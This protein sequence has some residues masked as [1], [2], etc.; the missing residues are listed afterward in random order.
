MQ[1]PIMILMITFI[2]I[3]IIF[4]FYL[5]LSSRQDKKLKTIDDSGK[6]KAEEYEKKEHSEI[7]KSK[8]NETSGSNATSLK[9]KYVKEDVYKL[10]EFDRILDDMIV[11]KNGSRF[12]MAIQCKG[13]NYDLMSEVE[14]LSVEEGFITFLNTLKYPIQLYVQAQNIDLKTAIDKFKS[15]VSPLKEEYDEVNEKYVKIVSAFDANENEVENITKKKDSISNVYEYAADIISYVEKM[16]LN[17]NLLQRKFYILVSYNTSD[18]AAVDKFSKDE[19]VSM[20]STELMTR[21]RAIISALASCSVTGKMLNSNEL[22]DLLYSA[23]N[24]DDKG[25]LSV[26]EAIESGFFRLYSTSEDAFTKRQNALDE[27]IKNEAKIRALKAMKDVIENGTIETPASEMIEQEEEISRRATNLVKNSNYDPSFES[28]VNKKILN[29][30]RETKKELQEIDKEQKEAI[31]EEYERDVEEMKNIKIEKPEGIE[32]I[33]KSKK[34]EDEE[35]YGITN[36]L[37]NKNENIQEI[38]QEQS[39]DEK[40]ENIISA[41]DEESFKPAYQ[42]IKDNEPVNKQSESYTSNENQKI[43]NNSESSDSDLYSSEE[44]ETII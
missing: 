43:D 39:R 41:S 5:I 25:I 11:Q 30:F 6:V 12:T 35:K 40:Q 38:I 22:A 20:C 1:L 44:D 3:F 21:C 10:M 26:K 31:K 29:D 4:I 17:K 37:T 23:Y 36:E 9:D 2:I 27:Y 13:I 28:A 8:K 7:E 34:Y 16:S 18:I 32:L 14:Q 42:K 15:N 19:I 24:R 33:E